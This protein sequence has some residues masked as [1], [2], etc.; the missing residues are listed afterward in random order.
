MITHMN[1]FHF[2]ITV[3]QLAAPD[4]PKSDPRMAHAE[5]LSFKQTGTEG[6]EQVH[7]LQGRRSYALSS[8]ILSVTHV[9]ASNT[10]GLILQCLPMLKTQRLRMRHDPDCPRKCAVAT[11]LIVCTVFALEQSRPMQHSTAPP[12]TSHHRPY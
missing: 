5:V 7:C 3:A 6:S 9:L 11:V 2:E 1:A 10:V 8:L 4:K 12:G